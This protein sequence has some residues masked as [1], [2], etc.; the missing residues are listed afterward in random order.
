MNCEEI[1]GPYE[2]FFDWYSLGIVLLEIAYWRPIDKILSI[3]LKT[4]GPKQTRAVKKRLLE[5]P[6]HLGLVRAFS[7]DTI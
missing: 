4:A 3:D 6:T 2:M 1:G 5:E 7:G